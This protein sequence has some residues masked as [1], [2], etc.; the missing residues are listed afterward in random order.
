MSWYIGEKLQK[1]QVRH[2]TSSISDSLFMKKILISIIFVFSSGTQANA[3]LLFGCGSHDTF[4]GCLNCS[5]YD[6]ASVC[7]KYG[8][9]G[10]KYGDNSIWNKYGSFGSKYSDES[11]WNKYASNPPVVVDNDGGFYGYFTANKYKTDRIQIQALVIL[12]DNADL[13]LDNMDEAHALFCE[14]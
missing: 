5:K 10:S 3:L 14:N 2:R 6:S 4:L 12:S 11:P 8:G 7:N 13:V 1:K 9:H